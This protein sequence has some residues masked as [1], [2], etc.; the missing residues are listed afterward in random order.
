MYLSFFNKEIHEEIDAKDVAQSDVE[1]TDNTGK[2]SLKRFRS[3]M[4]T[5]TLKYIKGS[6][7]I[8]AEDEVTRVMGCATMWHESSDEMTEMIKSIFR[9]DEDYSAR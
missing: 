6:E 3:K 2:D 7:D 9:I 4:A 8:K 1:S 5:T